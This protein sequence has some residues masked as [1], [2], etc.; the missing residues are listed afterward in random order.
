MKRRV[1]P[2][3]TESGTFV[4]R[5]RS[6]M[7]VNAARQ[8]K[9]VSI[10]VGIGASIVVGGYLRFWRPLTIDATALRPRPPKAVEPQRWDDGS[11]RDVPCPAQLAPGAA[12]IE[13]GLCDIVSRPQEFA[14]RRVR[15]RATLGTDCIHSTALEDSRCE[16]GIAPAIPLNADR[17][18]ESFFETACAE[19]PINFDVKR[20]ATFTGYFRLRE[21]NAAIIFV[22]DVESVRGIKINP[23]RRP[24][25]RTPLEVPDKWP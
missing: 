21:R 25:D 12:P 9:V 14:C 8:A 2:G 6:N 18:V 22:L 23:G 16:R 4:V 11:W 3:T 5:L 7:V 24:S 10:F 19:R 17:E 20:R 15:F 13:V 1:S